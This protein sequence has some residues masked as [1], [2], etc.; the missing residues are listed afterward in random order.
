MKPPWRPANHFGRLPIELF[1][2]IIF[3]SFDTPDT[4]L[5]L[6]R[7]EEFRL[8]NRAWKAAIDSTPLFW[9]YIPNEAS[10]DARVIQGWIKKSG[11]VPLHIVSTR[12]RRPPGG[13]MPLLTPYTHRWRTVTLHSPF[14]YISKYIKR[15]APLLEVFEVANSSIS[16]DTIVF[17]GVHP[18]LSTVRL[19]AVLLP[20][21]TGFLKNLKELCLKVVSGPSGK[22]SLSTLYAILTESLELKRLTID[23]NFINDMPQPPPILLSDLAT[24]RLASSV[25]LP[26]CPSAI[27]AMI[28]SPNVTHLHLSF[29]NT[30]IPAHLNILSPPAVER[31]RKA[32]NLV[33]SISSD[34]FNLST[35]IQPDTPYGPQGVTIGLADYAEGMEVSVRMLRDIEATVCPLPAVDLTIEHGWQTTE[36]FNY[37]KSSRDVGFRLPTLRTVNLKIPPWRNNP[38]EQLIMDLART[39]QDVAKVA[40]QV[41]KDYADDGKRFQWDA[42]RMALVL[43]E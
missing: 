43:L 23:S 32:S 21:D 24:F 19:S 41:R 35:E 5:R 33:I 8:V 37:L 42:G 40:I 4:T 22:L 10:T 27:L 20:H 17:S 14:C 6:I 39:R 30:H 25:Y 11:E 15:P 26:R 28:R 34:T 16:R 36:L 2:P 3:L 29:H 13:F 38:Y 18:V 9:A 7:T 12:D 31:L 1:V